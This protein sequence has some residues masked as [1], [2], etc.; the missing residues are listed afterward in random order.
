MNNTFLVRSTAAVVLAALIGSGAAFAEETVTAKAETAVK[1]LGTSIENSVDKAGTE[2][3][4]SMKKVDGFMDDST[5]TAKVKSALLDN[6]AIQSSDISVKTSS[7]AVTLRGFVGSDVQRAQAED[8][9]KQVEG[10]K[11]V[12]NKLQVQQGKGSSVG[13]YVDDTAI[14]SEVKA[15]LLADSIVPSRTV[16]VQTSEGAVMLSGTV[17]TEKQRA[18]AERVAAE[19]SGVKSVKNDIEIKP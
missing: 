11:S 13:G 15:K 6:K 7:G 17:K 12:S 8:I 14:T 9:A 5:I 16:K 18:Q 1:G 4:K 10:V 3:D 2:I 19:V